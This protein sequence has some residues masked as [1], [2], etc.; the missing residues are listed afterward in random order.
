[1]WHKKAQMPTGR[2]AHSFRLAYSNF[3]ESWVIS[4]ITALARRKIASR[5]SGGPDLD[6]VSVLGYPQHSNG[7]PSLRLVKYPFLQAKATTPSAP[8]VPTT[9]VPVAMVWPLA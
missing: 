4:P 7:N 3:L 2:F 9:A 6:E 8:T 1:M 5:T